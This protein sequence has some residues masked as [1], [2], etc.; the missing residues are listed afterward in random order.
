MSEQH[1][2]N[3]YKVMKN[4]S[5]TQETSVHGSERDCA[6]KNGPHVLLAW[7]VLKAVTTTEMEREPP[8]QRG[9]EQRV[10][11]ESCS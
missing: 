6:G 11:A 5:H 10:T 4:K 2:A 8:G 9:L 1:G 3:E 7:D